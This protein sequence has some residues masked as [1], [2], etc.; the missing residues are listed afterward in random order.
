MSALPVDALI[1]ARLKA[2]RLERSVSVETVA[3]RLSLSP[4]QYLEREAGASPFSA[5]DILNF[6]A[7]LQIGAQAI[8]EDLRPLGA[9]PPGP[10]H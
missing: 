6:C 8:F 2:L 4:A 10:A 9:R 1:G 7:L 5:A 3:R